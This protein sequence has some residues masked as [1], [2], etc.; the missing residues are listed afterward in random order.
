MIKIACP[1]RS[2]PP[3]PNT[4]PLLIPPPTMEKQ[5][6]RTLVGAGEV[7]GDVAR[8][9]ATGARGPVD[10]VDLPQADIKRAVVVVVGGVG[11]AVHGQ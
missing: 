6:S 3:P 11:V 8:R 2:T 5:A 1:E 4:H 7:G 10:V 9:L